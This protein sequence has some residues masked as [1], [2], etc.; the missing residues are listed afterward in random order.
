MDSDYHL[1]SFYLITEHKCLAIKGQLNN[2]WYNVIL[3]S[4]LTKCCST[5]VGHIWRDTDELE[6][7]WGEKPGGRSLKLAS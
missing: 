4:I 7:F 1:V 2:S 5:R 6:T 3:E